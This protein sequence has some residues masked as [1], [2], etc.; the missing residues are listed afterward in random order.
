M[1]QEDYA[2]DNLDEPEE[3][4]PAK[5]RKQSKVPQKAKEKGKE[6]AKAKK[7]AKKGDDDDYEDDEEDP[8]SAL[9]KMWKNDLPKPPIGNFENC[10]RC[11]KQF[12][13]VSGCSLPLHISS[14][15]T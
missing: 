14:A 13:V 8:Y 15:D 11:E 1:R 2:S 3:E 9:S 10:A 6:K 7:K 4:Q 12:T 5:K